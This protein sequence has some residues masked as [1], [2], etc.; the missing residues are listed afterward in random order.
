MNPCC[1]EGFAMKGISENFELPPVQDA[2][3]SLPAENFWGRAMRERLLRRLA[4]E[5]GFHRDTFATADEL[6][7][8]GYDRAYRAGMRARQRGRQVPKWKIF[9]EGSS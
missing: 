3:E 2:G 5:R 1:L 9:G 8:H 4:Y 6:R 7:W